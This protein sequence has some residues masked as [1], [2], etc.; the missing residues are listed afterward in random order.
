LVAVTFWAWPT[1]L[2]EE[3]LHAAREAVSTALSHG[4]HRYAP[5]EMERADSSWNR[6]MAATRSEGSR[7]RL[8][9]NYGTVDSLASAVIAHATVA[10]SAA[11]TRRDSLR[12]LF[13]GERGR[14]EERLDA[15]RRTVASLPR[16]T[17]RYRL[18]DR[19]DL[20]LRR[21]DTSTGR[22][23]HDTA[24]MHVRAAALLLNELD[25]D[26]GRQM[27]AYLDQRPVWERW[28][29]ETIR[30]S[31]RTGGRA[32]VVDKMNRRLHVYE[33]GKLVESLE[34]ELGS[35]WLGDKGMEGDNAT[36]EGKYK[37]SV[38]RGAGS[39][40][41]YRALEVDYP[42]ADDRRAFA[43]GKRTGRISSSAR[44]GGL[45]EI[46]GEGGKGDDWTN[47]CVALRNR[48][49]ERLFVR[50]PLGTPVTIVGTT[51]W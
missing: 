48:D 10:S 27:T 44:I 3:A 13:V 46:H 28:V 35:S 4:A 49:M 15:M 16:V 32:L 23:E 36:P 29:Q 37:V 11:T 40:R 42:N 39:T 45:I 20:A 18:L 5:A 9:R 14:T 6:L 41:Y 34:V 33:A 2:P 43:E 31:R 1:A 25:R 51:K 47:G 8:F 50:T 17:A 24:L 26:A 21:A 12:S 19:V 22:R 30:E 38:R 7:A